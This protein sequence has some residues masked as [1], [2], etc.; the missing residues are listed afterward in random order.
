[1]FLFEFQAGGEM[2]DFGTCF[3]GMWCRDEE[4]SCYDLSSLLFEPASR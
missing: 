4:C 1:M 2:D 3:N